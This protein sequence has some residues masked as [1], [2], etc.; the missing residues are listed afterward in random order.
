MNVVHHKA[1]ADPTL[2]KGVAST[3]ILAL[4]RDIFVRD[5][6]ER[7]SMRK[8]AAAA[9][10]AVGTIYLRFKSKDELF[11]RLV[12][13]RFEGLCR[14]LRGLGER[15]QNG[16]PVVLLKKAMYTYVEFGL[17]HPNDYGFAFLVRYSS[18]GQPCRVH[19]A[20]EMIRFM[21]GRC[22][23]EGCFREVDVETVAQALWAAIHGIT[24]LLIQK[25]NFPWAGRAKVIEQVI[26][27]AV[28]SLVVQPAMMR[29]KFNQS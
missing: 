24:S 28:D 6:Y 9:G 14:A 15:H 10:C 23:Q 17:R 2:S 27:N 22:V 29:A 19:P 20:F 21:V 3:G 11:Q 26:H 1:D 4:A 18:P 13:E 16:D 7:F 25:P 12:E 5:G 8:L